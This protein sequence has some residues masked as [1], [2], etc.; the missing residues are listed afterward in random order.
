MGVGEGREKEGKDC[1]GYSPDND[2]LFIADR[3]ISGQTE[4]SVWLTLSAIIGHN[5]VHFAMSPVTLR[6]PR[7][8][9]TFLKVAVGFA[10]S[11][12]VGVLSVFPLKV[13]FRGR[14]PNSSV[15]PFNLVCDLAPSFV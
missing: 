7:F 5:A 11:R 14:E 15:C 10:L 3:I 4:N 8:N 2:F 6:S 9:N 1:E 13:T 12:F